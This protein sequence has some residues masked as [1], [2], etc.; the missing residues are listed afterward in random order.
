MAN[1]N[2]KKTIFMRSKRGILGLV[3]C[4]SLITLFGSPLHDHD[5]DSSHVDLDCISCHLVQ[6]NIGLEGEEPNFSPFAQITQWV[7]VAATATFTAVHTTA[8]SRAPPAFL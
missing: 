6:S 4:F 5:L 8:S 1:L 7:S 3:F 2:H